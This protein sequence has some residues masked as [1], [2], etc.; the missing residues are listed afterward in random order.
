[1]QPAA[2]APVPGNGARVPLSS[3]KVGEVRE[4]QVVGQ[5]L[6]HGAAIDIGAE[7]HGLVRG[8]AGEHWGGISTHSAFS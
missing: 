4:G 3:L 8:E 7:L 2:G 6:Y 5:L 1:M